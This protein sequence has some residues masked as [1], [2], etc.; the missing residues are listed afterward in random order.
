MARM[1]VTE[2]LRNQHREAEAAFA[3]FEA[4]DDKDIRAGLARTLVTALSVHAGAEELVLYP[5]IRK[6]VPGG[7]ALIDRS[8][9]EHQEVKELL[10]QLDR[11]AGNG[12]ADLGILVDR[13]KTAVL[14]HATEEEKEVFPRVRAAVDHEELRDLG[15]ELMET[16]ERAPTHPH[17]HAP[18]RPPANRAADTVAFILDKARDLVRRR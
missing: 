17:P 12:D 10:V 11:A 6:K 15:R 2:L 14:E 16:E 1:D 18:N 7:P 4:S 3:L 5:V 8:L 9:E 13:L